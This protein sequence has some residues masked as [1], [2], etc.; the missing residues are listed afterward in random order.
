M[1]T[2][3]IHSAGGNRNCSPQGGRTDADGR[4]PTDGRAFSP[5]RTHDRSRGLKLGE[6]THMTQVIAGA[7]DTFEDLVLVHRD[8]GNALMD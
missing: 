1:V 2:R 6:V 8:V 3:C 7:R 4:T 5:R